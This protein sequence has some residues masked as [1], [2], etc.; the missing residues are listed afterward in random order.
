MKKSRAALIHLWPSLVVLITIAALILLA[1]YPYPFLQLKNNDQFSAL[2][3]LTAALI[4]PAMTWLM[5][6]KGKRGM[7]FDL[8]VITLIQVVA[9]GWGTRALY[10]NRPYFMVFTVDRFEVISIREVDTGS[11]DNPEFLNKPFAGTVELYAN[12]PKDH[13]LFQKLI[14]EV[15]FEGKPDIQFRP[16]FWS[17]YS[18]RQG[19][20]LEV[21]QP[22]QALHEAR[23]E[24]SRA[25]DTLV[26]AHG[27]NL[28]NLK[29]VPGL[30]ND[31]QFTVILDA[32]TGAVIDFLGINPWLE[33]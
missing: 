13:Q 3:I 15:M 11:I 27:G 2:L 4:G 12:M 18:D 25:I 28:N 31:G 32:Q 16:E 6:K 17:L 5:Y 33:N 7:V 30:I 19:L 24:A 9:I 26:Q 21:S 23:P 10:L 20:A 8:V 22:L 29:F 14:R 1:W